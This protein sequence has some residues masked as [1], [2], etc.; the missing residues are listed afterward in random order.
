M[1]TRVIQDDECVR[2]TWATDIWTGHS[3]YAYTIIKKNH[4]SSVKGR[5]LIYNSIDELEAANPT[6]YIVPLKRSLLHRYYFNGEPIT[7]L[8]EADTCMER[9]CIGPPPPPLPPISEML[10]F[11]WIHTH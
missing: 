9:P 7:P 3:T 1:E 8:T 5:D 4:A 6:K 10:N 11:T 2:L